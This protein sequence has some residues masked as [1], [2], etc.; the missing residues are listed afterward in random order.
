MLTFTIRRTAAMAS[1]VGRAAM[2]AVHQQRIR[3]SPAIRVLGAIALISCFLAFSEPALAFT[4][5]LLPPNPLCANSY[6]QLNGFGPIPIPNAPGT[7]G[8]GNC[9]TP[10]DVA[11][12]IFEKSLPGGVE[13]GEA[14]MSM[15]TQSFNALVEAGATSLPVVLGVSAAVFGSFEDQLII[16]GGTGSGT[17]IIPLHLTGAVSMVFSTPPAGQP[18]WFAHE[19]GFSFACSTFGL[20]GGVASCGGS[21]ISFLQGHAQIV[22]DHPQTVNR[23]FPLTIPFTFGQEFILERDVMV[24]AGLVAPFFTCDG[25]SYGGTVIADFS[26]TGLWD[27]AIVMDASGHVVSNPTILS[28][29]GLDYL[30]PAGPGPAAVPEPSTLAL[31]CGAGIAIGV[32]RVVRWPGA[33]NKWRQASSMKLTAAPPGRLS[34]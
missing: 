13:I 1:A 21:N 22:F 30:N 25:C 12:S 26:H 31:I 3:N 2:F 7:F 16:G 8:Q 14:N 28:L 10:P 6:V 24:S 34:C 17:M 15:A 33:A 9:V 19:A 18:D 23:T 4:T 20:M 5:G 32:W 29:S 11:N 27:P